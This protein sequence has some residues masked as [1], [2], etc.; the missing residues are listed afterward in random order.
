MKLQWYLLFVMSLL[1]PAL[2]ADEGWDVAKLGAE[3]YPFSGRSITG[4]PISVAGLKGKVAV[5]Y[6]FTTQPGAGMTELMLIQR[7][8]WPQFHDK[9]LV[10]IGVGREASEDE[11]INVA[12][13]LHIKF[14]LLADPKKEIFLHYALRGHPRLYL[15]GRDGHIKLTSLGYC[16]DELDRINWTIAKEL[17]TASPTG[18]P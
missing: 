8:M 15:V 14:P 17:K 16:D 12:A 13:S 5:L 7:D 11:L 6:F 9:G 3:P 4:E 18:A 2:L 10:I 1:G